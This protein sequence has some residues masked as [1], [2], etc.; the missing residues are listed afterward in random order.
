MNP[1]EPLDAELQEK[2][3]RLEA[4]PER[5]PEN[6]ARGKAAFLQAAQE[7]PV[8]S[9][10]DRR[11][12]SWMHANQIPS[13]TFKK[14]RKP[15]FGTLATLML[16]LTLVFGG[17][18]ATVA[19][20][21]GSQPADLLYGVKLA[22]E[23][24]Q[25]GLTADP[26]AEYQLALE[27]AG[28]RVLE[29]QQTLQGG[30]DLPAAVQTRY[31]DQVQQAIRLASNLPLDQARLALEQIL[32]R[33]QTQKQSLEQV[34][35]NGSPKAE[36]AL[37]Q[38]RQTLQQHLQLVEQCLADPLQ[39]GLRQ[40]PENTRIPGTG[41]PTPMGSGTPGPRVERT[42][43]PGAYPPPGT[44]PGPMPTPS[45]SGTPGAGPGPR[46]TPN[47]SATPEPGSG[48]GPG[49]GPMPTP[50]GSATPGT[51]PGPGPMPTPNSSATPGTGPGPGPMPTPNGSPTPGTGPGPGPGPMP[52]PNGS[53]TPGSGPGPGPGPLPPPPPPPPGPTPTPG[54]KR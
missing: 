21:Q 2:L 9:Q 45:A 40:N 24:V 22:A 51:G 17:G 39:C 44:G 25:L 6:A 31:Q 33:L 5:K 50:N 20:S 34:Q 1:Q 26:R 29:I 41:M 47:G 48:P 54:G 53:P 10:P 18:G 7:L 23:D 28:R 14:E 38:A 27:F 8:T 37:Q 16:I 52:T 11:H 19:A 30:S 13:M 15:M 49:P 35:A 46:P 3:N 42:P 12:S 32:A 43:G 4:F 36:A